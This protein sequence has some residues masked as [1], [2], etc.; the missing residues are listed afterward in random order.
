MA[1]IKTSS[2]KTKGRKLQKWVAGKISDLL[3]I[4]W[5]YEDD[6]KIQPRLMGQSGTD[7]ILRQEAKK[8]FQFDIECKAT[9]RLRLYQDIE[10][11]KKNNMEK[12]RHW[13]LVHKKNRNQPIAILDADVF[14]ELLKMAKK[15]PNN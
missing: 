14:F 4:P 12:N 6:K 2:A 8:L 15:V 5:G 7:I 11:A 1:T 13:L 3:N 9:E 10:Q